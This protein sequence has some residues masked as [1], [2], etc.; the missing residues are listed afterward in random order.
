MT[1][2]RFHV[3]DFCV[4]DGR[5]P[6]GMTLRDCC[7]ELNEQHEE[8]TYLEKKKCEYWNKYNQAHLDRSKQRGSLK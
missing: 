8:I 1:E 2:K 5:N 3:R 7:K 4:Y 6:I